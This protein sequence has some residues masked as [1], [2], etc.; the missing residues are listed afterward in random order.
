MTH[1]K[2]L[3]TRD[4]P[5]NSLVLKAVYIRP[6]RKPIGAAERAR[7][8]RYLEVACSIPG[9]SVVSFLHFFCF[10]A[11]LARKCERSDPRVDFYSTPSRI[12][13]L[14]GLNPRIQVARWYSGRS[15]DHQY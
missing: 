15:T 10:R 2:V 13:I 5:L 4:S 9:V 8:A 12:T 14:N 3:G 1:Q 6:F 7:T 11:R